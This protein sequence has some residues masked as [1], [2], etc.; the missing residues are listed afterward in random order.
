L[1]SEAC[2]DATSDLRS[3]VLPNQP[4]R[5]NACAKFSISRQGAGYVIDS[6][7][8]FMGASGPHVTNHAVISG[9]FNSKYTVTNTANVQNSPNAA[10]NGQHTSTMTAIYKGACPADIGPGQVKMPNGD[11][12]DMAQL[13]RGIGGAMIRRSNDGQGNGGNGYGQGN[14]GNG[15]GQ[16]NGGNG[17]GQGNGGNGYGQ[18]NGGNGYGQGNG[19]NGY[20]GGNRGPGGNGGGGGYGGPNRANGNQ[21]NN[22]NQPNGGGGP[23]GGDGGDE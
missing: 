7:C 17:Y 21:S 18:G 1:V 14:G 8:S 6:D 13:R 5:A 3:P 2:Y 4:K 20:G 9:D 11:V 19:G 15:Y 22:G 23:G 10:R 16:G 12:I